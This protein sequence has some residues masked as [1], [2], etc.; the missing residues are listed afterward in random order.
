MTKRVYTSTNKQK[1]LAR[2]LHEKQ[3][4]ITLWKD[5]K[6]VWHAAKGPNNTPNWAVEVE[7]IR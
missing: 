7:H 2:A 5:E 3:E 6:G 1:V 4:K